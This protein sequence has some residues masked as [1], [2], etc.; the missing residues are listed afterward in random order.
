MQKELNYKFIIPTRCFLK[1]CIEKKDLCG[2]P[3]DNESL[4]QCAW[5]VSAEKGREQ[6]R[7]GP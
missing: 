5:K 3:G 7:A 1:K 2:C 4:S 6:P